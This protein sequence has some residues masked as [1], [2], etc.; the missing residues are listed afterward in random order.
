MP[1]FLILLFKNPRKTS[2]TQ[3][4]V[5]RSLEIENMIETLE[6]VKNKK[7]KN[8]EESSLLT[9]IEEKMTLIKEVQNGQFKDEKDDHSNYVTFSLINFQELT[10][11]LSL[12]R[13][14]RIISSMYKKSIK[15]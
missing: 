2:K 15:Q 6:N 4:G 13:S 11:E 5:E 3:D 9:E 14:N 7:K 8:S 12:D 1:L 10:T